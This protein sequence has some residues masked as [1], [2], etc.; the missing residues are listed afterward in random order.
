M[1][2]ED[3]TADRIEISSLVSEASEGDRR[4]LGRVLTQV[5]SGSGAQ[6]RMIMDRC[7]RQAGNAWVI[8][9][10]GAPGAGKSTLVNTLAAEVRKRRR[11]VAILAVDPSSSMSGGAFLGDRIRMGSHHLDDGV[12]IRS[13]ASRGKLGGLSFA[14][15][16]AIIVL[17]AM[18]FDNIIVE[19][20]GVGQSEVEISKV[21]DTVG[22]VLAPGMGDSI[23]AAKAGI[24]EIA[25]VFVINKSDQPGAR[26]LAAHIKDTLHIGHGD[27]NEGPGSDW[28]P[29]VA[30]TAAVQDEGIAGL[31]D[32]LEAHRAWQW[33]TGKVEE[34][35]WERMLY[36]VREIVLRRVRSQFDEVENSKSSRFWIWNESCG[37]GRWARIQRRTFCFPLETNRPVP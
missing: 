5:E 31:M 18:G 22:V 14:V 8:G 4:A 35:W 15:P 36:L 28:S 24:C 32:V 12:Y 3:T 37:R 7:Y 21:A 9:L 6:V 10:T 2:K 1:M 26:Q 29:P 17:D 16:H 30:H 19:T 33:D 34:A 25:N 11:S 13:L 20:V 23:Q 27:K